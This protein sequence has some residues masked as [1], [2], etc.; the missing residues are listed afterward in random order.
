MEHLPLPE[1]RRRVTRIPRPDL[2]RLNWLARL[3]AARLRYGAVDEILGEAI[4]R[5]LEGRR[6]WPVTVGTVAFLAGVMRSIA[7]E[8]RGKAERDLLDHSTVEL[9]DAVRLP[10][11]GADEAI[12]AIHLV[13]AKIRTKLD[14]E[15][16]LLGLFELRLKDQTA[17]Q[18][19]VVLGLDK[20]AYDQDWRDLKD[21]ILDIFPDGYPL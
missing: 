16:R 8:W 15:P 17:A 10:G 18:I 2:L 3:Y 12:A 7:S 6:P 20:N 1:V 19:Q 14:N 4:T 9:E 13:I 21:R 5:A 11:N